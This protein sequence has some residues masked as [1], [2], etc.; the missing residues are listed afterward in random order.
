MR[1]TYP[2]FCRYSRRK[3][4]SSL[5]QAPRPATIDQPEAAEPGREK[6][7]SEDCRQRT[8]DEQVRQD[9]KRGSVTVIPPTGSAAQVSDWPPQYGEQP[10]GDTP[11]LPPG[12]VSP[13]ATAG[14]AEVSGRGLRYWPTS[15]TA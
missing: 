7:T 15:I 3:V 6:A 10:A 5:G 4:E 13:L 12:E 11:L 2:R 14:T 9:G 1:R 8:L